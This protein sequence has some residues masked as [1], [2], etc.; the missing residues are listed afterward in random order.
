MHSS[1]VAIQVRPSRAAVNWRHCL[2]PH[3]PLALQSKLLR[4]NSALRSHRRQ[5]GCRRDKTDR[6]DT[7]SSPRENFSWGLAGSLVG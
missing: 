1:T 3:A 6:K 2:K 5:I 7:Q 4:R